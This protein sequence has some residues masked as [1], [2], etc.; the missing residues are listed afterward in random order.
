MV[1][2]LDAD[3]IRSALA[4]LATRLDAAGVQ[5]RI[6]LMGGAAIAR[7]PGSGGSE[8]LSR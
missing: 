7:V 5:A 6:R 8:R 4:E 1:A 2:L 3:D